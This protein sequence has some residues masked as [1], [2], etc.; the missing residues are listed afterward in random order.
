MIELFDLESGQLF[1]K[2]TDTPTPLL[3]EL[4]TLLSSVSK[5][6]ENS[7]AVE[8][9]TRSEPIV[10]AINPVWDL[11]TAR[12]NRMRLMMQDSGTIH[13]DGKLILKMATPCVSLCIRYWLKTK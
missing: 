12:A 13:V 6:V 1:L 2:G 10:V 3:G 5:L 11:S 8:G 9:H 7:I 4:A